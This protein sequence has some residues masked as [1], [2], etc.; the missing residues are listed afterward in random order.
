[1]KTAEDRDLMASDYITTCLDAI[2]RKADILRMR[3]ATPPQDYHTKQFSGEIMTLVEEI[4]KW[5]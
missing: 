5:M 3:A 4:K 2:E 1:M